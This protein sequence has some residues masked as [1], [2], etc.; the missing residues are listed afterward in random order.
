MKLF[1]SFTAS[2]IL[3]LCAYGQVPQA[4][5][6]QSIVRG[7]SGSLISNQQVTFRISILSGASNGP[8]VYQEQH[9]IITSSLGLVNFNIGQGSSAFGSFSTI[10][11]SNGVFYLKVE[12]DPA[13]IGSDFLFMG[14]DRLV[15]VPYALYSES[16]ARSLTDFDTDST[17]EIQSLSIN[18]NQLTISNGNSVSLPTGNSYSSGP[19][20]V[21]V[22]TTISNSGDIDPSNDITTTTI[23]GGDLSGTYPSPLVKGIQGIPVAASIPTS[24]QVLKFNVSTSRWEPGTDVNTNYVA[25]TGISINGNT[26]SN[27]GDINA[28]DDITTS[29]VAGG[30][31]LGNFPTPTVRGIQGIPVSSNNPTAG[32]VLKFNPALN[33]WEPANDQSTTYL[34]GQGI[35]ISGTTIS[36][37]GDLSPTNEIQSLSISG[38]T[39]SLSNGGGSVNLPSGQ[40][41]LWTQNG[42]NIYYNSGAVSMGSTSPFSTSRLTVNGN[43][44]WLGNANQ[45]IGSFG[46]G[47]TLG[48]PGLRI[49]NNTDSLI[50]FAGEFN[51]HGFIGNYDTTSKSL[52]W[53]TRVFNTPTGL[54][55][56]G[57]MANLALSGNP[58]KFLTLLGATDGNAG[59]INAYGENGNLNF[60]VVNL[61]G[62]PNNGYISVHDA[63][64]VEQAGIF[65]NASGQGVVFGDVKNF[66]IPY[67]GDPEK[68]IWY[69]SVEGPEAAAYVRGTGTISNGSGQVVF[70]DHFSKIVNPSTLTI[71]ITPLSASSKGMA[72]VEKTTNGFKVQELLEGKGSYQFDWEAKAVRQGH[73]NYQPVRSNNESRPAENATIE[74]IPSTLTPTPRRE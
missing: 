34:A 60:R 11:W 49:Y 64:G 30:D 37:S 47:S 13:G 69:A 7:A 23:A 57:A 51:G 21:I 44:T 68:E 36:N 2:L 14:S 4:I 63:S 52:T 61:N 16:A 8:L 29:T 20:I 50:M 5:H 66:R 19:G 56:G 12:F 74:H 55:I 6:Y 38:N 70:P 45:R 31:L 40:S 58:Q 15:S 62:Y 33:L 17:N 25:G 9:S 71:I 42:N 26:I 24:G 48:L 27:A 35:T 32:Q 67:P 73:E 18:G 72:V 43:Q 39:I 1:L 65:V 3:S 46:Y 59:L 22:G 10:P 53:I 28:S 54:P 41:S